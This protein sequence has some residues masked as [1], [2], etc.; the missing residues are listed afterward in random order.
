MICHLTKAINVDAF[1]LGTMLDESR[2][3]QIKVPRNLFKL[4]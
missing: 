4:K 1:I 2:V 3:N